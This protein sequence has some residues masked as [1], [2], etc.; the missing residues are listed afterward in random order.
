MIYCSKL[1]ASD[2]KDC[3]SEQ[4]VPVFGAATQT[5]VP[6]LIDMK[7]YSGIWARWDVELGSQMM[8][9]HTVLMQFLHQFL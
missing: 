7:S 2:R 9:S 4:H 3:V 1:E 6:L 5:W 8:S